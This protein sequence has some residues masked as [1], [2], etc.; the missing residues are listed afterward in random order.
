VT[1]QLGLREL[2]RAMWIEDPEKR[3]PMSEVRLSQPS[4]ITV[5]SQS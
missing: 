3:P 2:I 1:R 4:C 5:S